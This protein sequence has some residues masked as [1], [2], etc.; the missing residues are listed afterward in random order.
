MHDKYFGFLVRIKARGMPWSDS[1]EGVFLV[2]R[3]EEGEAGILKAIHVEDA[4]KIP[5]LGWHWPSSEQPNPQK[6]KE[7]ISP[8]LEN[9]VQRYEAQHVI[10]TEA[11]N[12]CFKEIVR[13]SRRMLETRL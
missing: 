12:L 4:S 3:K 13:I 8:L 6:I 1:Q 2:T 5:L 10:N 9:A 7:I 11:K